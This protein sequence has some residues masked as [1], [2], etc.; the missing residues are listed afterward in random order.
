MRGPFLL[1]DKLDRYAGPDRTTES[2]R[3]V[4][5]LP[6][7]NARVA[8]AP[9]V[10]FETIGR[11]MWPLLRPGDLA[12]VQPLDRAPRPGDI[13]VY[14][15]RQARLVAHRVIETYPDG[16]LRLHG[17]FAFT[18]E[19]PIEPRRVV[20]QLTSV[21][22]GGRTVALDG[23]IARLFAFGLPRLER[24]AP[25]AVAGLRRSVIRAVQV[26]DGLWT[27][28][29][30]RRL[31]RRRGIRRVVTLVREA[32]AGDLQSHVRRSGRDPADYGL[33]P[34]AQTMAARPGPAPAP[35]VGSVR[36]VRDPEIRDRWWLRDLYVEHAWRGLGLGSALLTAALGASRSA[37]AE[38]VAVQLRSPADR[39]ALALLRVFAFKPEDG[40]ATVQVLVLS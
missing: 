25:G 12:Q 2:Q 15:D 27:A 16:R 34:T 6:R 33:S 39:R 26:A 38:Q 37:G 35:V 13:L 31:R 3:A 18:A 28:A 4:K 11:S 19:D 22:R 1:K 17:D 21:E 8:Y 7:K 29:P 5:I 10:R 20:G 32:D 24:A 40:D 36:I 23:A 30:V 9:A 14:V